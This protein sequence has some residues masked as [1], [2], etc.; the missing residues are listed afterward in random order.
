M[1][2]YNCFANERI[3]CKRRVDIPV[4]M[5]EP[6]ELMVHKHTDTMR[7]VPTEMIFKTNVGK[8]EV[9]HLRILIHTNEH[10][11]IAERE[12]FWHAIIIL[13]KKIIGIDAF[14]TESPHTECQNRV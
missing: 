13:D 8:V 9:T 3:F 6:I 2:G 10:V 14:G 11:P 7:V 5:S 12:R 4:W 1:S